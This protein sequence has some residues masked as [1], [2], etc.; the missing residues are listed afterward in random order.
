MGLHGPEPC[1]LEYMIG[2]DQ[3][4]GGLP[5]SFA[6]VRVCVCCLLA[7]LRSRERE[8]WGDGGRNVCIVPCR[9]TDRRAKAER[10]ERAAAKLTTSEILRT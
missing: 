9:P 7:F 1:A 8:G 3:F 10:V 2:V 5:R 4:A 6:D